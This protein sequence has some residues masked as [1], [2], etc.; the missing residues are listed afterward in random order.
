MCG[1]VECLN[2]YWLM[3]KLIGRA[4]LRCLLVFGRAIIAHV[5]LACLNAMRIG[6]VVC[7]I[8]VHVDCLLLGLVTELSDFPHVPQVAGKA[9]CV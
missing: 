9:S 6:S 7:P 8:S 2:G 3:V 5:F 1:G 4:W